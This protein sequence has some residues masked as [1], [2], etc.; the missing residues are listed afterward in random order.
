MSSDKI[1]EAVEDAALAQA[2]K[3]SAE[4]EAAE[5]ASKESI[6]KASESAV[7]ASQAAAALAEAHAAKTISENEEDKLWLKN[8]LESQ[9]ASLQSL[10]Q[11]QTELAESF[12]KLLE[13]NRNQTL[14]A[15][16]VLLTP[17]KLEEEQTKVEPTKESAEE[18]AHREVEKKKKAKPRRSWL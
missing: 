10:H 15:V 12:P 6:A 7:A 17:P 18:D 13:E 3:A 1:E 4:E 5:A 16:K 9:G 8:N 14:E 11:R 2:S